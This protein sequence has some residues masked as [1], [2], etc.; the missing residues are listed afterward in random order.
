[1]RLTTPPDEHT[2]IAIQRADAAEGLASVQVPATGIDLVA[3]ERALIEFA[4]DVHAGNRTRAARFLGLSRSA[5]L[6][7]LHKYHLVTAYRGGPVQRGR[8]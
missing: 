2:T 4:L 8:P 7:R 6:Y 1:M 5:L 3:V